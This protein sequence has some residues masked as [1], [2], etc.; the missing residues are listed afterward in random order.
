LGKIKEG[1]LPKSIDPYKHTFGVSS[2][3]SE[4]VKESVSPNK[5]RAQVELESSDK[6][7]MYKFTHCD[8]EPGEQKTRSFSGFDRNQTFG[9]KT[10]SDNDG[11][12]AKSSLIWLPLNLMEKRAQS[13]KLTLDEF[14]EKTISQRGK[15]LDPSVDFY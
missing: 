11:R 10:R 7:E 12:Q 8:Y 5:S 4:S 2:N 1:H 6:H 15:P 9:C 14:K 3:I 13:D